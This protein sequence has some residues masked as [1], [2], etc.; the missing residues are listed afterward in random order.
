[1]VRVG[2]GAT[3][4]RCGPDGV[5]ERLWMTWA[6]PVPALEQAGHEV[7]I[8]AVVACDGL[9]GDVSLDPP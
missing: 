7:T 4:T 5:C 8:H 6:G 9:A 1:M 2:S 3:I